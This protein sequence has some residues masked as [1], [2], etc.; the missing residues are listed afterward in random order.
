MNWGFPRPGTWCL[1]VGFS[2]VK[3]VRYAEVSQDLK[4]SLSAGTVNC[5]AKVPGGVG[6]PILPR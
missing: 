6:S 5:L 4:S 2:A 1:N 3:S